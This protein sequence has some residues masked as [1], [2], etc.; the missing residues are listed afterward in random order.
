ME[1][2]IGVCEISREIVVKTDQSA[3]DLQELLRSALT[4]QG[5]FE[6]TGEH[7]RR[8]VVPAAK[9]AYLD[10]GPADARPVGFGSVE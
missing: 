7:G 8:V 9:I 6:V 10:F 2:K 4:D 5:L 1:I 3:A